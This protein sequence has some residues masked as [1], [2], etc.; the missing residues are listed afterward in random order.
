MAVIPTI[1]QIQTFDF[2]VTLSVRLIDALGLVWF[3]KT[4][5]HTKKTQLKIDSKNQTLHKA[6][7][8]LFREVKT[9]DPPTRL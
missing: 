1:G 6:K 3:R 9:V 2:Q 4:M 5:D 8:R 7:N